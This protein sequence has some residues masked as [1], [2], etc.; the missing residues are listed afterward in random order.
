[1]PTQRRLCVFDCFGTVVFTAERRPDHRELAASFMDEFGCDE[2]SA[3]RFVYLLIAHARLPTTPSLDVVAH[4]AGTA[5]RLSLRP[6]RLMDF[7]WRCFG[8]VDGEW[9]VPAGAR[10]TLDALAAAGVELRMITN[11]VLAPAQMRRALDDLEIGRYFSKL[12]LSSEGQGKKPEEAW[13]AEALAGGFE[14]VVMVG[15]S[16]V[17]DIVPARSLGARTVRILGA[18]DW[19]EPPAA[20]TRDVM[21]EDP[22]MPPAT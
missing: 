19:D 4:V 9:S 3:K 12:M 21:V 2:A 18:D 8:P 1:M 20:L 5:E 6:D 7:L 16:E 22:V 17:F 15:D 13:F 11:C 14:D 10:R